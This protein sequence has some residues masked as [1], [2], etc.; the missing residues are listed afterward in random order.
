MKDRTNS[1]I[2]PVYLLSKDLPE[3][4]R[5]DNYELCIAISKVIGRRGLL[6]AQRIGA[7]W[8]I[9]TQTLQ[10]RATILA[11]GLVMR[12]R[13]VQVQGHNP[14]MITGSDGEEIPGTKLIISEIPIPFS[15]TALEAALIKK[16][17]K[18]RSK[19]KMEEVRDR[20]GKIDRMAVR[21]AIRVY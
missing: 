4:P 15:N 16:G 21:Q 3:D 2:S 6:R 9:Y 10:A 7:L 5:V 14:Y 19:L 13:T 20:E 18:L 1:G 17:L 12:G 8:R 11:N